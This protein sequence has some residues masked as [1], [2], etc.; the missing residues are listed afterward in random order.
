MPCDLEPAIR[1]VL[2]TPGVDLNLI[3]TKA[4][5]KWLQALGPPLIYEWMKKNRKAIDG[6]I[7][8]IFQSVNEATSASGSGN[9]NSMHEDADAEGKFHQLKLNRTPPS[10]KTW[11]HECVDIDGQLQTK[12]PR[13]FGATA[14]S[15]VASAPGMCNVAKHNGCH[16]QL[17]S[18]SGQATL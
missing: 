6:V 12:G 3:S 11:R 17:A 1:K 4:V 14:K 5:R 18:F 2:T 8:E 16:P 7:G 13:V 10:A 9:A 15:E